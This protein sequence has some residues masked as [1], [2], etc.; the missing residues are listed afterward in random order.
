MTIDL[1]T[2]RYVF[3]LMVGLVLVPFATVMWFLMRKMLDDQNKLKK[4]LT[5]HQLDVALNYIQRPE[6]DKA[7]MAQKED[8]NKAVDAIFKKLDRIEDR[9]NQNGGQ[10][11]GHS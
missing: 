11:N 10:T 9:V 3:S 6:F 1:E 8:F 5:D 4:A 7:V 2:A